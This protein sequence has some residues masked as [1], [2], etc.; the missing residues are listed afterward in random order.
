MIMKNIP[1]AKFTLLTFIIILT[2]VN[3]V[4]AQ[5]EPEKDKKLDFAY[6]Q[7]SKTKPESDDTDKKSEV[8]ALTQ[9]KIFTVETIIQG[10]TEN[11][12]KLPEENKIFESRSVVCKPL[13]TGKQIDNSAVPP[14]EIYKIGVGDVLYISLQ[15]A[16]AKASTYFTVLEDGTI[17]YPLAGEMIMVGGLTTDEVESLLKAKSNFMKTRKFRLKCANMRATR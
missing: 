3:K 16:P 12:S 17:D 13:E 8:G 7:I 4:A 14:T 11:S 1:T 10:A 2:I 6:S 5:T 15:N 9:C